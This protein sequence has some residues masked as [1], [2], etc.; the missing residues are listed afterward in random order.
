MFSCL[1]NMIFLSSLVSITVEV[2]CPPGTVMQ[3]DQCVFLA[4]EP[5]VYDLA[6]A[7]CQA[8]GGRL[9]YLESEQEFNAIRALLNGF[10][11]QLQQPHRYFLIGEKN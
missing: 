11:A 8:Q 5:L 2:R 9:L 10:N 1:I 6:V 3:D 4:P 7:Q